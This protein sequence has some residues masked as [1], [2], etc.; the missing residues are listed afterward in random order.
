VDQTAIID[1]G[2]AAWTLA[3]A[4]TVAHHAFKKHMRRRLTRL[5]R[6]E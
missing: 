5:E 6:I 2:M 4:L 1:L 3:I